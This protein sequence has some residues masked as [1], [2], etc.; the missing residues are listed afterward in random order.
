[1]A[2]ISKVKIRNTVYDIKDAEAQ[3]RLDAIEEQGF[4]SSWGDIT[5]T[6][7]NQTDLQAALDSKLTYSGA[8]AN[9]HP[10]YTISTVDLVDGVSVLSA[11]SLYFYYEV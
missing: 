9:I 3:D 10:E 5:G 8:G 2:N 4:V 7:S 6:L 1:M 11:G